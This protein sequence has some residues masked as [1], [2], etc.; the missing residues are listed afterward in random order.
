VYYCCCFLPN[1]E[2]GPV[3]SSTVGVKQEPAL[4]LLSNILSTFHDLFGNIPW[5][6]EDQV[7]RHIAAI[8]EIV[9]K[10]ENY[11]NAMNNSD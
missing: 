6:D 8:L 4:D 11:Q 5:K 9:A 10:D 3:S 1:Y 2:I 7:K